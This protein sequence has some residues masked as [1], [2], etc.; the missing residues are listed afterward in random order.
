MSEKHEEK[1]L[2]RE[3]VKQ[4]KKE[5]KEFEREHPNI[6]NTDMKKAE[7]NAVLMTEEYLREN[8]P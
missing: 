2:E 1:K 3:A 5:E 8:Q 7:E 4:L 6:Y